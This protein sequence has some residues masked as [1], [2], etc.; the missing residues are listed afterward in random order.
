MFADAELP[1]KPALPER[2]AKY[3]AVK[4]RQAAQA[5]HAEAEA[6]AGLPPCIEDE[7]Y[8]ETKKRHVVS[9]CPLLCFGRPMTARGWSRYSTIFLSVTLCIFCMFLVSINS[10]NLPS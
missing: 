4:A 10:S 7:F 5:A 8:T 6:A 9:F 1:T 2:R 3:D